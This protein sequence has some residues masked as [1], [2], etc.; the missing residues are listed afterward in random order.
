MD[1]KKEAAKAI[2]DAAG[3]SIDEIIDIIEV[4]ADT[5]MGDLAFPCFKLAKTLRKAPPVIAK[6]IG[7][8]IEKN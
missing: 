6:E 1:F 8:K 4:P 3:M 5:K 2:A 7:E